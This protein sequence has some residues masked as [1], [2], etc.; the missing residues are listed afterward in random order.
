MKKDLLGSKEMIRAI[1]HADLEVLR[2]I[3][4]GYIRLER[5]SEG[6]WAEAVE[7]KV[8]LKVLRRLDQIT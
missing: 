2:A 5:F 6:L 4:T 7:D 3:L 1:D 8:F